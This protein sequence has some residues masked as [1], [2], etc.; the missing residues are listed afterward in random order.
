MSKTLNS[1]YL[2]RQVAALAGA[3]PWLMGRQMGKR[4]PRY[5][6]VGDMTTQRDFAVGHPFS[7]PVMQE[8]L[9]KTVTTLS[10]KDNIEPSIEN[11]YATYLVKAI[12]APR[13]LSVE[14]IQKEW[15]PLI[16][17]EY[18]LSGCEALACIGLISRQFAGYMSYEPALT[19]PEP[20]FKERFIEIWQRLTS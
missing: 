9:A 15:L 12:Y 11:C 3:R 2:E 10:L 13:E 17:L 20:T 8:I 16:Q 4:R 7:G 6:I 19:R 5:F 14:L 18:R 1:S